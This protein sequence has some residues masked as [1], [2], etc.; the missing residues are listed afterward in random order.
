MKTEE[1]IMKETG[2]VRPIDELGR[3]VLPM[4]LRRSFELKPKDGVE[5]YTNGDT[6]VL[7]KHEPS[8]IF[9]GS[10]KKLADYAD[11]P[12]CAECVKK[13]AVITPDED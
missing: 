1:K 11:K 5:I 8:C 12:I 2:I 6:I 9:C 13:I 7:K 4:E 10:T 3:L